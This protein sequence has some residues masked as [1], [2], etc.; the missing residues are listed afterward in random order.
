MINNRTLK[1]N[2]HPIQRQHDA[3]GEYIKDTAEGFGYLVDVYD[4]YIVL[5]GRDFV[6]NEWS[7]I[8]TFKITK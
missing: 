8:G 2:I 6:R 4:D 3:D 5:R 1:K 7:G